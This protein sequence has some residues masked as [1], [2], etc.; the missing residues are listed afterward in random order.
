MS[1]CDYCDESVNV[2]NVVNVND[3]FNAIKEQRGNYKQKL[4]AKRQNLRENSI[5]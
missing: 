3:I 2:V 1:E 4:M 5:S